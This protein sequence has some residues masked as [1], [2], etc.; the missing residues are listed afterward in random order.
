[1]PCPTPAHPVPAL[2]DAVGA[3][4]SS[5]PCRRRPAPPPRGGPGR[6]SPSPWS[7]ACGGRACS[8]PTPPRSR[9]ELPRPTSGTPTEEILRTSHVTR[10]HNV[11]HAF[12]THDGSALTAPKRSAYLRTT[13]RA[14]AFRIRPIPRC[15]GTMSKSCARRA[16]RP[17]PAPAHRQG[18]R[19]RAADAR[20]GLLAPTTDLRVSGP[21]AAPTKLGE[22]A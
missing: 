12:A 11:L 16:D 6:P 3:P 22:A 4:G 21:G 20:H 13:A 14:S 17:T 7:A 1:M 9:A 2:P 5:T 15:G 19:R 8:T 10:H 18:A